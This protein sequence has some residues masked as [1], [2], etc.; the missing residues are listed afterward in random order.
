MQL[1]TRDLILRPAVETDWEPMFRNLWRHAE[2]ARYMFWE[3]SATEEEAR[4]RI[5]RT[6]RFEEQNPLCFLAALRTSGEA[7]G[8]AGMSERAPGVFEERGIALGPAYTGRGYGKQLLAALLRE[9]FEGQN[10]EA[11]L[12]CNWEQNAPS[13][14]VQEHFGFREIGREAQ[15]SPRGEAFVM[16]R[17]QL[18]RAGYQAAKETIRALLEG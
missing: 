1:L 6:I 16:E 11:F 9:A 15:T 8:F 5:R 17:R 12:C 2:S 7:I 13:R 14:R 3:P 4:D 10:A 18:D